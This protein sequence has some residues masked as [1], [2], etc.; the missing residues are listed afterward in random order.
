MY[1]DFIRY[2]P[3]EVCL[4]I[5]GYLDPVSLISVARAC[6]AWYDLALDRK[7]WQQLY[8]TEGWRARVEE[9]RLAEAQVNE[10]TSPGIN[11][12]QR[13]LSEENGHARKKRAISMSPAMDNDVDTVMGEV[14]ITV[15]QEPM[16]M[17][18]AET[19][20]FGGGPSGAAPSRNGISQRVGTVSVQDSRASSNSMAKLFDKFPS[21]QQQLGFQEEW[22]QQLPQQ[23]GLARSTLWVRDSTDEQYRINWKYLYTMRRRLESN[24]E[25][26]KFTNFQLPHPDFPAEG[27][28]EC[29]YSLQYDAKY[30]VSGSRDC[31]LKVWN[32]ETRRLVRTLKNHRGSVLCLQFDADPEEDIIVSGSSDSDV[33]IWRFSTGETIQTLSHAHRE[34]VLNVKFDKRILVTCS[35]DKTIKIFNRREL[36]HGDL[37]YPG[38][39]PTPRNVLKYDFDEHPLIPPFTMIGCLE[40]HS[41]AVNAVQIHDREVVSASGDRNIKVWDW[42]SQVSL[43]HHRRAQQGDCLRAIRWEADRQRQQRQRGKGL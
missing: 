31:T 22:Q 29:I 5:L 25:L 41:A 19:S 6:R 27:H 3:P 38:L 35:K 16:E 2:L 8:Y 42:P 36:R 39:D 28:G 9:I 13:V 34:S 14:D 20:I 37:G 10:K 1:I 7:L 26:G 18:I 15:R 43:S 4:K 12:L 32:L 33:I 17:D 30:L 23:P 21:H 24:W 11:H 40:G